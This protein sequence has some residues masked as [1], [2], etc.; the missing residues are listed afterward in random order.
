MRLVAVSG[1][2]RQGSHNRKLLETAARELPHGVEFELLHGLED[3]PH[4]SEDADVEPVHPAVSRLR[5]S[6]RSRRRPRLDP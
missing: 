3:I 4:Y 6:R 2:P 5:G 1:S